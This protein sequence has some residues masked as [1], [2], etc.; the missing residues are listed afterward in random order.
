M[1]DLLRPENKNKASP[2][3]KGLSVSPTGDRLTTKDSNGDSVPTVK[4]E[5]PCPL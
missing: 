5:L 2:V 4:T 1:K 3:V